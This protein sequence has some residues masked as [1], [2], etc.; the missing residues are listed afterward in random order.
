[1]ALNSPPVQSPDTPVRAAMPPAVRRQRR[2][3]FEATRKAFRIV[4]DYVFG[5]Y[6]PAQRVGWLRRLRFA[7]KVLLVEFLVYRVDAVTERA[8]HLDLRAGDP[9]ATR[10]YNAKLARYRARFESLLRRKRAHNEAVARQLDLGE[11][12]VYLENQVT[13]SQT[14]THAEVIRLA[15]LRPSDVRLLNAMTFA[16]A[17]RPV[18]DELIRLLWPVEV[19]ADIANDLDHYQ[20]D[21]AAGRFNTYDAF[22][23]LY[24]PAAPDRLRDEIARYEGLVQSELEKFPVKRKKKLAKL[25]ARRYRARTQLIPEPLF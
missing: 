1:M 2:K 14:A 8:R 15:E 20:S 17:R 25:T 18:D 6:F 23:R 7:P 24:G 9:D 13:S 22:V 3:L 5:L 11:E 4:K 19:L 10:K 16:L 21:V 12:F